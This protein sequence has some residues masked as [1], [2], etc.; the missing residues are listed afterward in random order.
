MKYADIWLQPRL[1]TDVALL[2]GIIRQIIV[3]D[4]I[5]EKFIETKGERG[6][7]CL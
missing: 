3:D 4:T 1:G 2:N 5:D 6:I 7:G